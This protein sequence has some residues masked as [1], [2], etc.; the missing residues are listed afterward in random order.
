MSSLLWRRLQLLPTFLWFQSGSVA[1]GLI[2]RLKLNW[3]HFNDK[4]GRFL[5]LF[6][7]TEKVIIHWRNSWL[8]ANWS[9]VILQDK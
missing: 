5:S 2:T 1:S 8:K 7:F 6:I 4:K 9:A 3:N